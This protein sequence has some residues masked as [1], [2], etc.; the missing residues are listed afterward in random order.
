[1]QKDSSASRRINFEERMRRGL[2]TRRKIGGV[3]HVVAVASGKGGV[4]KSTLAGIPFIPFR[5]I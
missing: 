1:M 3:R 4:G 5:W 2:P